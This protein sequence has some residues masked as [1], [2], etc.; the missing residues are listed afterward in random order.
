MQSWVS[1]LDSCG[2]IPG[3]KNANKLITF[4]SGDMFSHFST[5]TNTVHKHLRAQLLSSKICEWFRTARRLVRH[6]WGEK[7]WTRWWAQGGL[8][9][10]GHLSHG[11]WCAYQIFLICKDMQT[12]ANTLYKCS[13]CMMIDVLLTILTHKA[14]W[15]IFY[16]FVLGSHM[17]HNALETETS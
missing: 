1:P 12:Y 7:T 15:T 5:H 3:P 8:P 9:P 16:G 17:L 2:D 14:I 11:G 13:I 10:C 6:I 4:T